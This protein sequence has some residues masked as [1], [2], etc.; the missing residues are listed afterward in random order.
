[1]GVEEDR[2]ILLSVFLGGQMAGRVSSRVP[3]WVLEVS[4]ALTQLS[5]RG[6]EGS[7][8]GMKGRRRRRRRVWVEGSSAEED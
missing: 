6:N 1:M 7:D 8:A 4:P 2:E 5:V 3:G